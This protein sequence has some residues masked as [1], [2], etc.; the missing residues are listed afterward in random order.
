ML[1]TALDCE[2]Y[3]AAALIWLYIKI[4]ASELYHLIQEI[5]IRHSEMVTENSI[6]DLD[7][8][9]MYKNMENWFNCRIGPHEFKK[10]NTAINTTKNTENAQ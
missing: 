9:N 5:I 7:A 6:S 10:Y 2:R 1:K 3:G 4:S 8:V